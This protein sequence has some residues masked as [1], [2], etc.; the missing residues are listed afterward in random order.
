MGN[1]IVITA[2]VNKEIYGFME[3]VVFKID[4]QR[5]IFSKLKQKGYFKKI[6]EKVDFIDWD[7]QAEEIL[8]REKSEREQYKYL[9]TKYG[10]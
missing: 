7:Y 6:I 10:K 5:L 4:L 2:R 8:A 1:I 3:T 9:K